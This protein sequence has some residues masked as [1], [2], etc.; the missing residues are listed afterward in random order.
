MLRWRPGRGIRANMYDS[1]YRNP[2]GRTGWGMGAIRLILLHRWD[3]LVQNFFSS[4]FPCPRSGGFLALVSSP[5]SFGYLVAMY[6]I[7]PWT[8]SVTSLI[9][10]ARFCCQ[11]EML[12]LPFLEMPV[13]IHRVRKP[14]CFHFRIL[15]SARGALVPG[16]STVSFRSLT[17]LLCTTQHR[18][19]QVQYEPVYTVWLT[20][21]CVK[22]R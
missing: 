6:P 20:A 11:T 5:C 14:G 21:C 15:G 7:Y 3:C 2:G 8:A 18:G 1:C 19:I 10:P 16:C 17:E 12:L 4:S 22:T 9:C 13:P